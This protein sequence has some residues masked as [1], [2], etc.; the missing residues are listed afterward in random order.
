MMYNTQTYR[1]QTN[2]YVLTELNDGSEFTTTD[3]ANALPHLVWKKVADVV[4][5]MRK[6][7]LIEIVRHERGESRPLRYVY[8][9]RKNATLYV[10]PVIAQPNFA[11]RLHKLIGARNLCDYTDAELLKEVA[12]RV[13]MNK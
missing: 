1:Q 5:E 11:D 13:S 3:V 7:G 4:H 9:V 8:R 2:R 10:P 6:N 12:R